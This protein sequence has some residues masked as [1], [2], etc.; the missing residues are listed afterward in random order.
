[1]LVVEDE[2][3]L[4]R[5]L[6][7]TLQT[8][9]PEI[10]RLDEAECGATA[11]RHCARKIPDV[12]F[13]DVHLPDMS[14]IE[15]AALLRGRCHTVFVTSYTDYAVE[16]FEQHALD[17][18][19]KPATPRRLADTVQRLKERIGTPVPPQAAQSFEELA[20]QMGARQ[21]D[22]RWISASAG[23]SI[24]LIPIGDV[25]CFTA[26]DKYTTVVTREG[27]ALI[28]KPLRELIGELPPD[29]FWQIHRG[30]IVRISAI[31]RVL[32]APSGH[33]EVRLRGFDRHF[34]VSRSF[35]GLFKQM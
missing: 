34:V 27:E 10:G 24:Q 11:M 35:A 26:D 17:Y 31:E 29:Q 25:I 3:L 2:P 12:A 21:G 5:Q 32:R 1:V 8:L 33:L 23:S 15:I 6:C 28:R 22:L 7:E 14:G 20:K 19:L 16:A 4:R 18:L 30:T 13:L 9:W